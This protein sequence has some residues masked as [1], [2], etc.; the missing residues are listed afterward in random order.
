[1]KKKNLRKR[2][3]SEEELLEMLIKDNSIP[4]SQE[5]FC[6]LTGETS[7]TISRMLQREVLSETGGYIIWFKEL[8]AYRRGVAAGR[9]GSGL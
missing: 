8:I 3:R 2:S 7:S 1:M 4:V 9:R 6:H 5:E